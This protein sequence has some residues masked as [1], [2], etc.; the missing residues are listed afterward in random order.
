MLR[1]AINIHPSLLPKYRGPSPIQTAILDSDKVPT[2]S[3]DSDRSVGK[4][5]VSIIKMT[6]KIDAGPV[7][8]QMAIEIELNDDYLTLR[9]RLATAGLKALIKTLP[10]IVV[11]KLQEVLQDED[12]VI[13]THKLTKA[14]GEI[15]W[16]KSPKY[17]ERQ[18]RAFYPWPGSYTIIDNKRLIIHKANI[19][20]DKLVLE[21]VQPEGKKPMKFA[22]F[23]RGFHGEKPAWFE[24][25]KI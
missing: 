11:D 10:D 20:D 24:K 8:A 25:I 1:K 17:I 4:T 9:N 13:L 18:I 14:D 3:R 19:K 6:N 15:D 16:K 12:K 2:S 5:G 21:I 7:L 22:D 23:L